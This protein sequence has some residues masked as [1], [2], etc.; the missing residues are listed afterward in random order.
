MVVW[1]FIWRWNNFCCWKV[2]FG[3]T[4]RIPHTEGLNLEAAGV[5]LTERGFIKVNEF[6]ETTAQGVYALGDASGEK[7]WRLSSD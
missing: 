2:G 1:K 3:A 5:E 7:N 6:Q 4:G